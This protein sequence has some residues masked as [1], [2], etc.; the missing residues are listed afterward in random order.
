MSAQSDRLKNSPSLAETPCWHAMAEEDILLHL[1]TCKDGLSAAE[2]V[3]RLQHYGANILRPAQTRSSLKRFAQQ[4]HNVLVYVLLAA[5]LGSALL[6]R[7]T[8]TAVIIAVVLIN[9]LIGFIQEGKAE[10]ALEAIRKMLSAQATVIRDGKR[11]AIPATELV[12][13]DVVFVHSG[14]RI[15]ADMR[16]IYLKNLQVQEAALTGESVPVEKNTEIQ[17]MATPLAERHGMTFASTLVTMGQGTGIVVATAQNTEI[18]KISTLLAEVQRLETPLLR[19][20]S[21]FGTWLSGAILGLAALTFGFGVLVRGYDASEMFIAAVGLAVAAIPEGLP[22]IMSVALAIGV[23]RMAARKAIIRKLPAVET[24]G[25]L[26][27][28]CS[29]KTGTLT[30][31]EMTVQ[32]IVTS[33]HF[34]TVTRSGY[35]PSGTFLKNAQEVDLAAYPLLRDMTRGALLCS[36]ATLHHDAED[37]WHINGDPTEGALVVVALKAGLDQDFERKTFVRT[38]IIPFESAHRFMATL[39]HD[40]MGNGY[41]YVKGAPERILEMCVSQHVQDEGEPLN[42][43]YWE[44]RMEEISARGQRILALARRHTH[45]DHRELRFSDVDTNL[46]FLGLFGLA[47]PPREEAVKAVARCRD[48][49]IRV[50]MIT[51]DHSGTA[52]AIAEQVHIER[53]DLVMSGTEIDALNDPELAMRIAKTNVFARTTPEH[54]LRLVTAL[55]AAGEVVAMTGDG[56]NDAPALKRADVGVAMGEKGTEAAKEAAE[57]VLADDNFASLSYAIEEG[58][59]VYDNL[60]KAITF[61]L[62]TNGGE[63]L[64]IISAIA[65]GQLSPITPL[66]ILWVN[67]ITAVT[68]ALALAFE[69]AERGVMSRPPRNVRKPILSG[70][71]MWRIMFVSLILLCGTFGLFLWEINR[72]TSL[73]GA[74]TIAVNTLVLFEVFYLFSTRF[75]YASALNR[76]GIFGSRIALAA[77]VIVVL[78][79]MAFT[80]LGPMQTVFATQSI[81]LGAWGRSLLVASLVLLLVEGEK[82]LIRRLSPKRS[83]A[84]KTS[85]AARM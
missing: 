18:G 83:E 3:A 72:G 48:A 57:M 34:F 55:Q 44:Q 27:V 15:P 62:P 35:T 2:A 32:S 82:A 60:I 68:L 71:L 46:V 7:V 56:V 61:I 10:K 11:F 64:L 69:P 63:A 79:Q 17:G 40:H 50:I 45:S 24:L 26:T 9:A 58:R 54:K 65:F 14:D 42:R 37:G 43:A 30:R 52:R 22:A 66:Q 6:Q 19:Q 39:H 47:D 8:D 53:P 59:T 84:H 25:S 28:I 1:D 41:I 51:G 67:M 80:Y 85:P 4:F 76:R 23:Q 20:M 31:N 38:D 49:G 36:D 21:S 81:G 12:P 77:I 33:R 70:F 78:L 74:R 73:D 13:G 29:D 5:A 75:L 16:L